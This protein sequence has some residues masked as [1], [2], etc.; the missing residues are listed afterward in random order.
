[1]DGHGANAGHPSGWKKE[2]NCRAAGAQQL[3]FRILVFV[4]VPAIDVIG[5][6]RIN[7]GKAE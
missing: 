2:K 1:M 4:L 7:A 6:R 5:K 3:S